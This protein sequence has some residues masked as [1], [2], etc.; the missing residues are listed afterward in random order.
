MILNKFP[1][2]EEFYKIYWNKKPF[3][4]RGA[5]S[6]S[7]F[8]YFVDPDTL[9][10]LS[11]EEDIK[12]RIVITEAQGKKW[13]CEH[14]PFEEK[15]YSTLGERNWSLLV[16]N[17]EQ[18]HHK[19]ANLLKEFNF[20]PRWLMDD[21]MVSYSTAGGSVGPHTDS[22][23]VFLVQGMGK[24]TW[25]IGFQA[26]EN[27]D[28]IEGQDLK[29]LKDDFD[30][31]DVEVSIGDVIYIPPNFAHEGKTIEEALTFSVGFLGP[32]LSEMLI[33][34]GA[35]IEEQEEV[36]KHY[37]GDNLN[38]Q[39]AYFQINEKEKN[40]IQNDLVN[41]IQTDH[42]SKWMVSYFS[43]PTHD[44]IENIELRANQISEEKLQVLLQESE[45][46]YKPEHIKLTIMLLD[47]GDMRL[48]VYGDVIETTP[49]HNRLISWL[50]QNSTLS[51][52]DI[53]RLGGVEALI[54]VINQLYNQNILCFESEEK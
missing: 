24:R 44:E 37:S 33:E 36:D 41:I 49:T 14:G 13:R 3:V 21:I 53:E 35:Y 29:V 54:N 46:L 31:E 42:F 8:D 48:A 43:K 40:N 15:R 6:Q 39:N 17:V 50:D 12:S 38:M 34:Y 1:S 47:N 20:A 51:L 45:V 11:L 30:G 7:S 32:K 52:K 16:Q 25:R 18:Y 26:V 19:T 4:V 9:A 10:G 22:Y 23:H 27:E 28:Y 2:I 5:I